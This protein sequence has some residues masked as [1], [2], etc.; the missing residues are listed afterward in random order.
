MTCFK[1]RTLG[2]AILLSTTQI[3]PI[4]GGGSLQVEHPLQVGHP[5][6][7]A[8]IVVDIPPLPGEMSSLTTLSPPTKGVT[9]DDP[10]IVSA[11]CVFGNPYPMPPYYT[12]M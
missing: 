3:D 9:T 2:S 6:P 4:H 1:T 11:P 7:Q 5:P 12:P 8:T 10:S